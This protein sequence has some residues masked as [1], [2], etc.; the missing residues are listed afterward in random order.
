MNHFK[1]IIM[2]TRKFLFA[3]IP[4]LMMACGD[5][6]EGMPGSGGQEPDGGSGTEETAI[7]FTANIPAFALG[8]ATV[9]NSW[10]GLADNRVAVQIDGTVKEY[11]VDEQGVMTAADPFFW[12]GRESVT[13]S[14]WY[15]YCD[16]VKPETISVKSD[17]S[18]PENYAASDW[19]EAVGAEVRP[20][21][22]RLSFS[23]R[24]AKLVCTLTMENASPQDAELV[25]VG[26]D[27]VEGSSEIKATAAMEALLVPQTVEAGSEFVRVSIPDQNDLTFSYTADKD[28]VF[29][30][31]KI[32]YLSISVTESGGVD[33]DIDASVAW[34]TPDD[35]TI[36][37]EAT[38]LNPDADASWTE[39]DSGNGDMDGS[40]SGLNP[41]GSASWTETDSGNGDMEGSSSELKPD[42]NAPSW[43]EP[44][45][46]DLTVTVGE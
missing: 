26:L 8:R 28:F 4:F 38:G 12:E 13:V 19:L 42:G 30:A 27:G 46:E 34:G 32:Y 14:A 44:D 6:G 24:T 35:E 17:Q 31:G 39:T 41:D 10:T 16:G 37:G 1:L 25:F 40:S 29:E 33:V 18:V 43:G 21:Y 5:D 3:V 36:D 15:P 7:A 20:S 23:H 9:D 11:T 2:K 22:T 45:E